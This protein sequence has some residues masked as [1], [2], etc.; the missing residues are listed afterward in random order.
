MNLANFMQDRSQLVKS[1]AVLAIILTAFGLMLGFTQPAI[2]LRCVAAILSIVVMLLLIPCA[3]TKLSSDVPLWQWICLAAI[4]IGIW[5][6]RRT[7]QSR[8]RREK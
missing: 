8:R 2:A 1:L 4:G 3:V 5:Q 7:R 6:W